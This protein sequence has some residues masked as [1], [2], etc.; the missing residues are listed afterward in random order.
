[1]KISPEVKL[2]E[3]LTVGEVIKSDTAIKKGIDNTPNRKEFDNLKLVAENVFQPT[4][5]HFGVPIAVTSGFR[6]YTLNT[7]IGGAKSSDHITGNA[8]DLDA[9]VYGKITNADIFHYIKDNLDFKQLIWEFGDDKE[10]AWVHVSYQEGLN[11]KEVLVA[12]KN[13]RNRTYYEYYK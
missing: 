5:D 13:D 8:L 3:N 11:K 6:C 12:K 9:D 1:M 7:I 4:R 10:P 2:S